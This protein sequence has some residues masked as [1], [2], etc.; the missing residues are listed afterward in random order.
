M[1]ILCWKNKAAEILGRNL[2]IAKTLFGGE[3]LQ[4]SQKIDLDMIS[5][6]SGSEKL[7]IYKVCIYELLS[8]KI[9]IRKNILEYYWIS[10][11][12]AINESQKIRI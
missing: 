8:T 10:K 6:W 7:I 4:Q 2:K 9:P 5:T 1:G 3:V 12:S 11:N